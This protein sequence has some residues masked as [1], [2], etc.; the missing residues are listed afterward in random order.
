[1]PEPSSEQPTP[2]APTIVTGSGQDS[3]P[4]GTQVVDVIPLELTRAA[5]GVLA[6]AESLAGGAQRFAPSA[7]VPG[8]AFGDS[9][10][11]ERAQVESL[12]AARAADD[13]VA[14]MAGLLEYDADRL[15]Q[16]AFNFQAADDANLSLFE[17]LSE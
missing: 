12:R 2:S 6:V 16:T 4:T 9:D 15:Y 8:G 11:A 5:R 1:M 13:A 3:V 7:T 10:I 14:A 17:E